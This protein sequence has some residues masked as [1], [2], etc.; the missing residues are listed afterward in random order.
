MYFGVVHPRLEARGRPSPQSPRSCSRVNSRVLRPLIRGPQGQPSPLRTPHGRPGIQGIFPT[1]R[2][3]VPRGCPTVPHSMATGFRFR[4]VCCLVHGAVFFLLSRCIR[5]PAMSLSPL[6]HPAPGAV[7]IPLLSSGVSTRAGRQQPIGADP[8]DLR[9]SCT[10]PPY[11]APLCSGCLN[12]TGHFGDPYSWLRPHF[13]SRYPRLYPTGLPASYVY[14]PPCRLLRCG[15]CPRFHFLPHAAC[16]YPFSSCLFPPCSV[17]SGGALTLFCRVFFSFFLAHPVG[18]LPPP[19][20]PLCVR[21]LSYGSLSLL[22][23][24]PS[25]MHACT[26]L[27]HWSSGYS[28][29]LCWSLVLSPT[30][31][32]PLGRPR[33]C[34]VGAPPSRHS[35]ILPLSSPLPARPPS[36]VSRPSPYCCSP[37]PCALCCSPPG[38]E[39][40]GG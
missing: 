39:V 5:D 10:A 11:P 32:L 18:R 36:S 29:P 6:P 2:D 17:S 25:S 34:Q 9:T 24:L 40:Y 19:L 14:I 21:A 38:H 37:A 8:L 15:A 13:P 16:S 23:F 3:Q 35:P 4:R 33:P 26:S 22:L 28:S 30:Q 27:L 20:F 12:P 31:G 1:S 7:P